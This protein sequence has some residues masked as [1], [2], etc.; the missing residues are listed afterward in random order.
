MDGAADALW[1]VSQVS[2]PN[3]FCEEWDL[4]VRAGFHSVDVFF[5]WYGVSGFIAVK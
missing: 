3:A 1:G 2:I 4:L 5:A